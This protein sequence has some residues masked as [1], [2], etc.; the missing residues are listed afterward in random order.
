MFSDIKRRTAVILAL[1][2]LA[3]TL[4]AGCGQSITEPSPRRALRSADAS[5]HDDDPATCHSGFQIV[6][7]RVVCTKH[8]VHD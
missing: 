7:G 5:Q 4:M 2:T 3:G 1:G 8:T 6:D